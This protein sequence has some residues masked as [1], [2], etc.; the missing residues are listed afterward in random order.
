M[1]TEE[2]AWSKTLGLGFPWD[3]VQSM[4]EGPRGIQR[5]GCP[6]SLRPRPAQLGDTQTGPAANS[7]SWLEVPGSPGSFT[8]P[9]TAADVSSSL[10][11]FAAREVLGRAR[12]TGPTTENRLW[13]TLHPRGA[14][15]LG[16]PLKI[17]LED[18][19]QR[20]SLI[21]PHPAAAQVSLRPL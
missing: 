11:A 13:S 20:L 9:V 8:L 10:A 17:L 19:P 5:Q 1:L 3:R 21:H 18:S 6:G 16:Q 4:R 7:V 15:E 14:G 2:R 12:R